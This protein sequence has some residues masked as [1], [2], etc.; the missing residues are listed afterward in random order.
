MLV[1][2]YILIF[3]NQIHYVIDPL[4]HAG[5][6]ASALIT[7]LHDQLQFTQTIVLTP[8]IGIS[9]F[10]LQ[11]FYR[12]VASSSSGSSSSINVAAE[13]STSLSSSSST[14]RATNSDSSSSTSSARFA[15]LPR[16]HV[17]TARMDIPEPW[18][19]QAISALQDIDNLRCSNKFCGDDAIIGGDRRI[20][21]SKFE[22]T[23][24]SY[25]LKNIIVAGQ[26]FDSEGG[27]TSRYS[28]PPNGLQLTLTEAV[29]HAPK[30]ST[31]KT[32]T[33]AFH[34]DTLVMQNLGYFQ[35]Q[36][37]PGLYELNLAQGKATHLY[38]I[39]K[40]RGV[41]GSDSRPRSV[42][43][44]ESGMIIAVRSFEDTIHRLVVSKRPGKQHL[45][46]LDDLDSSGSSSETKKGSNRGGGGIWKSLSS[47]LFGS[48]VD[49]FTEE[50]TAAAANAVV[51]RTDNHETAAAAEDDRIHVFSLATGHMY[52]RL[53]GKRE[54]L[55][56]S[57][58][59][60][61]IIYLLL[62]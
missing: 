49:K 10:P 16:Q 9:E 55:L 44:T 12:F 54:Q 3:L 37:N 35:M 31:N 21:N 48:D 27:D 13:S 47:S 43:N 24:I 51:V 34:A 42:D 62:F 60:N 26:C 28:L 50:D 41:G 18:N 6:R 33:T 53:V 38:T 22:L 19:V 61:I 14:M 25:V 1:D 57:S 46:L 8:R 45:T 23:S 30:S 17:L 58:D 2:R 32:S 5:Q 20:D 36:A 40:I 15:N 59:R 29:Q 7:L 11:N 4:S 56:I 52:E 39:V